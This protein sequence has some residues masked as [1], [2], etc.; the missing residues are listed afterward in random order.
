LRQRL[1][2]SKSMRRMRGRAVSFRRKWAGVSVSITSS[3]GRPDITLKEMA[4][5]GRSVGEAQNDVKMEARF[6]VIANGNIPDRA[7]DFALIGDLDLLVGFLGEIEPAD[8][9]LF[10]GANRGQRCGI[11]SGV[12]CESCQRS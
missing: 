7:Q 4:A 12:I 5:A 3:V 10:E 2:A 1:P 8:R 6:A 11:H 9:G